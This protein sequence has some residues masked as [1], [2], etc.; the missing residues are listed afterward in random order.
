[1]QK[2]TL[3]T[4]RNKFKPKIEI[5][6]GAIPEKVLLGLFHFNPFMILF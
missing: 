1:M 4:R 6:L 2:L 3:L 5:A